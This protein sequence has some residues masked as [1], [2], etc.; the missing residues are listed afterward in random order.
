[1]HDILYKLKQ[2]MWYKKINN[3]NYNIIFEGI[4]G[5]FQSIPE[6]IHNFDREKKNKF[7]YKMY[8]MI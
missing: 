5:I 3:L 6:K 8:M 4:F 7:A 2:N 1:M